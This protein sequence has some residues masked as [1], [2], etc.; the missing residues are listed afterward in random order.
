MGFKGMRFWMPA[1][2]LILFAIVPSAYSQS[3]QDALAE[4]YRSNPS[5]Q[6]QRAELRSIDEGVAQAL[7][8][9]RPTITYTGQYG[10]NRVDSK[11]G[12]FAS[13][14]LRKPESHNITV[15]QPLFRGGRTIADTSRAENEVL[16]ARASLKSI[17]QDVLL[18]ASRAY[19][20]VFRDQAVVRL[21]KSNEQVLNR[22]LQATRDRFAVGEVTRTDVSQGEA[23]VA[24]AKADRIQA[25]GDLEVS[26]AS[27]RR[28]VG[29]TA[30]NLSKPDDVKGLPKNLETALDMSVK[31]NPSVVSAQFIEK[32]ARDDVELVVGELLPTVSVTGELEQADS[33]SSAQ[34][35][36]E[37]LSIIAKLTL[38]IY[39]QGEVTSRVREAKQVVGQRRLEIEVAR[40]EAIESA[41]AAWET[42]QTARARIEAFGIEIRSNEIALEGVRQEAMVGS[43]TV[44]DVL[45]AE[46]ELL[47]AQ[48]NVVR[49]QRDEFVAAMELHAAVGNLT[50]R[51]VGLAVDYY[52]EQKHYNKVRSKIYGVGKELSD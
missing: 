1:A 24:R 34:S 14:Q 22:Q 26:R 13:R 35:T 8:N 49:A 46:Q 2:A 47:D 41:N 29:M 43:R 27:Y 5:L 16:A 32:A 11:S 7:S 21:T 4:A 50:A 25:E 10:R 52:D 40:R 12:F 17:E 3:L 39:Q 9:W 44:L 38:P 33:F 19:M 15:E 30:G 28:V 42:L 20:D 37:N 48:V 31:K 6:A 36:S 23:R 51:A 45:D 18:D